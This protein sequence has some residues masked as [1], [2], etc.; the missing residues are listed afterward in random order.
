MALTLQSVTKRYGS[1]AALDRVTL[2]VRRGDLYGFIGHNGAGKTTAMRIALGLVRSNSGQVCVEGFDARRYRREARARMG[3]LIEVP[4]FYGH[5]DGRTNLAWLA[6]LQGFATRDAR[7]EAARLL[8]VVGL[9]RAGR[10]SVSSYSHGMRQRLGIAQ[11]LLGSPRIVLLDEPMNGLDP[12][13]IE[14][15]RS[16]LVRLVRERDMT[17]LLSSHQLR[18]I[19]DICNRVG[20]LRQ[21]KLLVE[22]ETRELL[23]GGAS[24]YLLESGDLPRAHAILGR[25]GLSG[26]PEPSGAILLR[27]ADRRPEDVARALV[28][29]G[30]PIRAFAP[31]PPS[32]E[33]V[34]L[35]FT[36]DRDGEPES[37]GAAAARSRTAA[38]R[39]RL[40]PSLP[41]LRLVRHELTRW[42]TRFAPPIALAA[43]MILGVT[44][45][46]RRRAEA[47]AD[48][49]SVAGEQ[50]ISATSV[51]AFEGVGVALRAGLPLAAFV[52]AGLASQSI[53]GEHGRGTL[54]NLLLRPLDR[55]R[56]VA[57]GKAVAVLTAALAMYVLLAA[58]GLAA[59]AA[60]FDFTS[61]SEILPG[62][63]LYE[64]VP[65]DTLWPYLTKAFLYPVPALAA[66][67]GLGFLVGSVTRTGTASLAGTFGALV[68]LDLGRV[69]ARGFGLEGWLPSA[70]L[71]SPLGDTSYLRF[72]DDVVQGVSNASFIHGDTALLCPL[73]WVGVTFALSAVLLV[74]RS[75]P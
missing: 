27:L 57:G 30:V 65:A 45:V 48:A 62:G 28:E 69:F 70:H 23:D 46:L 61:V 34:Y 41:L 17:V 2:H 10:K 16:L 5:K 1:Q 20:I 71:P 3:G 66:Y 36:R 54:R 25:L 24:R 47:I 75:V 14:E 59:S 55:A 53:A 39:E 51:T 50:L 49:R 56:D 35:R 29:G 32:L 38:P 33:E 58:A 15:M 6:R 40:A 63:A 67:A 19:S 74:R 64:L 73:I 12:E 7:V 26:D 22:R 68:V 8:E 21:G 37:P 42:G 43:P 18:E 9:A 11:A 52:V 31:R 13:G 60:V 72:F 4:G 44:A